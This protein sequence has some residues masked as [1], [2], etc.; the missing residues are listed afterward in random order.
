[1]V[2]LRYPENNTCLISNVLLHV[3]KQY[4]SSSLLIL[5]QKLKTPDYPGVNF[6]LKFI[7]LNL[8]CTVEIIWIYNNFRFW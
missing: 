3:D 7:N 4:S 5:Q 8:L 1:M 6:R 2:T